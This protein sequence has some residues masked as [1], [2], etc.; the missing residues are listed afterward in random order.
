[1]MLIPHLRSCLALAGL[2]TVS[3]ALAQT[4]TFS[5]L[6]DFNGNVSSPKG[7]TPRGRLIFGKDGKIYG[8]TESGGATGNFGTIYSVATDGT[9][10]TSVE[11]ANAV[12]G[13]KPSAGLLLGSDGK[14]YGVTNAGGAG[15]SP[16]GT[17]F[18]YATGAI[19][20]S[21]MVSFVTATQSDT[22]SSP[23]D[24][25]V[26][27]NDGFLYG[28]TSAGGIPGKGVVFK[29][30]R[31]VPAT[32]TTLVEFKDDVPNKLRLGSKPSSLT[33]AKDGNFYGTTELGGLYSYGT[34]FKV[35][36]TGAL[37]TLTSFG[38]GSAK[39][40]DFPRY[41]RAGLV[42]GLDGAF[43]GV[44]AEGG[45][46]TISSASANH[47]TVFRITTSGA[48]SVLVKFTG[49]T[50]SYLGRQP[51][52]A[53]IQGTDG[54]FYGTT[55]R[56]GASDRGT[57]F[58]FKFDSATGT[59]TFKTLVEFTSGGTTRGN[60]PRGA[61]LQDTDGNFYGTTSASGAN[62]AGIL[63]KFTDV[64]PPKAVVTSDVADT[65]SGTMATLKGTS[66]NPSGTTGRVGITGSYWFEYGTTV[67]VDVTESYE[68]VTPKTSLAVTNTA[69]ALSAKVTG[70]AP[71]TTYHY[72]LVVLNGGGKT[73]GPDATF[74]TGPH[75]T[76][77]DQPDDLL[78]GIGEPA[79][80]GLVS[81]GTTTGTAVTYAWMKNGSAISGATKD[82]YSIAKAALT[83]AGTYTAKV[84][85]SP[86]SVIT[87][88]ARLGVISKAAV[89]LNKLQ[90]DT[91][92]LSLPNAA[93]AGA[94][95]FQWKKGATPLVDDT[96][97]IVG[98]T[99]A[100]LMIKSATDA[101]DGAYTCEVA[102]GGTVAPSPTNATSGIYT[103][104]VLMRPVMNAV[105]LGPWTTN[106][107]AFGQITAQH[108]TAKT[109][110]ASS[111]L[112][113]G[114]K[115]DPKTGMLSGRP[116]ND[117]TYQN[118]AFTAINEAGRCDTPLT[119]TIVVL[120]PTAGTF[121]SYTGV[122]TRDSGNANLGGSFAL[123]T[124]V[125]G[126]GSGTIVHLGKTYSFTSK[127]SAA[128]ASTRDVICTGA[129]G[130]PTV[131]ASIDEATGL[132]T[133]TIGG[134]SFSAKRKTAAGTHAGKFNVAF[135]VPL[136]DAT[137]AARP[138]GASYGTL[139]IAAD[140]TAT[141][142]L[143]LG[144]VN[145][146][147]TTLPLTQTVT[148]ASDGTV[149]LHRSL[150][151]T[152]TGSI[153]GTVLINGSD[154]LTEQSLDWYKTTQ[155]TSSTT[156]S[157]KSGFPLH[158]LEADGAKY[159]KPGTGVNVLGLTGSTD[160]AQLVFTMGGLPSTITQI[161]SIPST[162]VATVNAT[163]P[164]TVTLKLDTTNG[165]FS[166]TFIVP[167]A[168]P[169]N[170]RKVSFTGILL[171]YAQQGFG[172][173]QLPELPSPTTSKLISGHVVLKANP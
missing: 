59:T 62:G 144:D 92:V 81:S 139:T 45:P 64:L 99:T 97:H 83:S 93:P 91:I 72:R 102:L 108:T 86:D 5:T 51:E 121:G 127:F 94:L 48:M 109:T 146:T 23:T 137:N 67:P 54:W 104:S 105:M 11:F 24:H 152:G 173:F 21:T 157:Y 78:V 136:A 68:R 1:M 12:A 33:L 47:G 167:D 87:Q 161:V 128:P 85:K 84:T 2:L 75:P 29:I 101:D 16:L 57:V 34:V 110:F 156:R 113:V 65:I 123:T 122:I 61:L 17:V 30:A 25:L 133:G 10:F 115:L 77:T 14:F 35:T 4:P 96:T 145:V 111:T 37:T 76:I 60:D 82:S 27:G 52:A 50:G 169:A 130:F 20:P 89:T 154:I 114:V 38:N 164:N 117:G 69:K 28:T 107:A 40:T 170:V 106:G 153:Q 41:P 19:A 73:F 103:V 172:Q 66:T 155:P 168:V 124:S 56:G 129:V 159:L 70:L 80:F 18:Q 118:V 88:P 22:G 143:I 36:P 171:P 44:T 166:G 39:V 141:W 15:T 90:G 138:Q 112:P 151:A 126:D 31:T 119:V 13:S 74:T 58:R 98:A 163:N 9:G 131:V 120:A 8:T 147:A 79:T 32:P 134:A 63:F 158:T 3:S 26:E 43:Y 148:L 71:G 135:N 46:Q 162:N 142:S 55:R 42:Q 160:N 150:Y 53:L 140:G 49:T 125:T 149:P 100:T 116:I 7:S 6:V 165:K 95:S 132:I